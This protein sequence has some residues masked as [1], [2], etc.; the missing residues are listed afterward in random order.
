M[1]TQTS[2]MNRNDGFDI[3]NTNQPNLH[4]SL[5]VGAAPPMFIMQA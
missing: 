4:E 1:A 5:S 2:R 3:T